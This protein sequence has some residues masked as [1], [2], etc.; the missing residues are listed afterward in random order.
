MISFASVNAVLFTPALPAIANYFA[1]STSKAQLTISWFLVGYAIGQLLYG[2]ISNRY[3]RKPALY[4]GIL[5]Q[6]W[7]SFLCAFAG[8]IHIYFVLVLGRFFLAL[9][10]GVGLKMTFTLVNETHDHNH[11]NQKLSY[12]LLAFAITPGLSVTLGGLLSKHFGWESTFY[13]SAVYGI[14]L[15]FLIAQL[16]ETKSHL[17]HHALQLKH[18]SQSYLTQ[19][20]NLQLLAGGL[21]MGGGTCFVYIFAALAPFIAMNISHMSAANYGIANLLPP[22]G[23]ILGSIAS[24]QLAH[25]IQ[26]ELTIKI[27]I[28]ISM[29]G[30]V[31]MLIFAVA[32]VSTLVL[33]FTPMIICYFGTSLIFANASSIAM[34]NVSD[35]AHGSAVMSFVNMGSVTILVLCLGALSINTLLLPILYIII[36]FAMVGFYKLATLSEQKT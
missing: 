36:S 22:I 21:L 10:A 20:K 24:A 17:D 4:A 32:Q 33:L 16:P 9:G 2:P 5:L 31:I 18:L 29:I 26:P 35:K 13:A 15:L 25:K 3:G 34:R 28:I 23:L 6:I 30:S 27:G 12:L 11:A 19:F 14:L 8:I 7:S 1:I